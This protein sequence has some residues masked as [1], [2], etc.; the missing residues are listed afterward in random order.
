MDWTETVCSKVGLRSVVSRAASI[1]NFVEGRAGGEVRHTAHQSL[2][3][4]YSSPLTSISNFYRDPSSPAGYRKALGVLTM[5]DIGMLAVAL[6][7]FAALFI[8]LHLCSWL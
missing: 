5:L 3:F 6:A 1:M 8:Y 4:F 7:S 2:S